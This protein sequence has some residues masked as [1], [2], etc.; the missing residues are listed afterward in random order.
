MGQFPGDIEYTEATPSGRGTAVRANID[1]RT[2]A[3]EMGRG[4]GEAGGAIFE[5][6]QKIYDEESAAEYSELKRKFDERGFALYNSV[7]GDISLNPDTGEFEGADV[8]LWQNFEN[9]I[10]S[11]LLQSKKANVNAAMRQHINENIV[12][13]KESFFKHG[14]FIASKNADAKFEA[15][16]ANLLATGDLGGAYVL[17]NN[18]RA[19]K[20]RAFQE[21]YNALVKSAPNDSLLL[22]AER[23][24]LLDENEPDT[25]PDMMQTKTA[26]TNLGTADVL[27]DQIG[28]NAT[29]E[30]LIQKAQLKERGRR[31]QQKLQGEIN[32]KFEELA[33]LKLSKPEE[34]G[35]LDNNW[36]SA[37]VANLDRSA[38]Y[39]YQ[40]I[41]DARAK[42]EENR[43]EEEQKLK[44]TKDKNASLRLTARMAKEHILTK[45]TLEG[46]AAKYDYSDADYTERLNKIGTS[47][48]DDSDPAIERKISDAIAFNPTSIDPTHI[49]SFVG[50]GKSGGLSLDKA[51]EYEARWKTAMD[52]NS[53]LNTPVAKTYLGML[54]EA[55][56]D[57]VFSLDAVKNSTI[58]TKALNKFT[59][60]FANYREK[61]KKDP[62]SQEAQEFYENLV[63]G[64]RR[65][66]SPFTDAKVQQVLGE[67]ES[68]GA[69]SIFGTV[70]PFTKPEDAINH[71]LRN[72]GPNWQQIAP[73][74]AEIIKRKF[75]KADIKI[76]TPIS[77]QPEFQI[78][79]RI[80]LPYGMYEYTGLS[81]DKALKLVEE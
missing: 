76:T 18:W 16:Y 52:E 37:N 69:V 29:N 61:N 17:L 63:S 53:G 34:Y 10:E 20:G 50:K 31:K 44:V 12:N 2:G 30:Q 64:Y 57:R 45:P 26:I 51:E 49:R 62:T 4:F 23:K 14:L 11:E 72:L 79:Q 38:R 36:L 7:T 5:I 9:N 28:E 19:I 13:L 77:R 54:K 55:E 21:K 27:L 1:V 80:Q 78:G 40:A 66:E 8:G 46:E 47:I 67:L 42:A 73:E 33:W 75:P 59:D 68:G 81:G 65:P 74:A 56:S 32:D 22:Q 3:E 58:Y 71:A 15:E 35:E 41:L 60:Y 48:L 70:M 39:H 43:Q 24:M 25:T 6:G